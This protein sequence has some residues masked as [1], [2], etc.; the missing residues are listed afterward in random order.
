MFKINKGVLIILTGIIFI[1]S[2]TIIILLVSNKKQTAPTE[3][4]QQ[5]IDIPNS[6]SDSTLQIENNITGLDFNF[7]SILPYVQQI[8]TSI[9]QN[10][11][12]NKIA[13]NLGFT[14]DPL[15]MD[16]AVN[17]NVSIWNGDRYSLII[18][19]KINNVQLSSNSTARTLVQNSQ[20]KKIDDK[21][22][23]SMAQDFLTTKIGVNPSILKFSNFTYYKIANGAEY[24]TKTTKTE[25]QIVQLN[26]SQ[27][28]S[29]YPIFTA[30]P[31]E[32]QFSIQ[33]LKN[34]DILSFK[35]NVGLNFQLSPNEYPLLTFN[36][37]SQ[38]LDK[39]I[40]VSLNDNN[41]NLPD[42]KGNQ[43]SNIQA[44][45]A[46][47]VYLLDTPNQQNIQPV[48]LIEGTA[49]VIGINNPVRLLM[50][51]PAFRGISQL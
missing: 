10:S 16:D 45:K 27:S 39:S 48:F 49:S 51:L 17:G 37:F 21:Q 2:V 1:V 38:N 25:A 19:P 4:F 5:K 18:I 50:Y 32:S 24:L 23:E 13:I 15:K 9:L 11:D 31:D 3:N 6:L 42:L 43:I 40:I 44:N 30:N 41:V 33:F 29:V 47:L 28:P 7:P 35:G 46:S 14:S 20:D 12:I 36:Q 8:N 34:G 22:F 26:Y